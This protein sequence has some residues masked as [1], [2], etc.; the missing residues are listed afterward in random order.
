MLHSH[1][2][3]SDHRHHHI[4]HILEKSME[5]MVLSLSSFRKTFQCEYISSHIKQFKAKIFSENPALSFRE[6]FITVI[7]IQVLLIAI[8]LLR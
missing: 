8:K 6:R 1:L 4:H 2:Q 5:N 7:S 3:Q